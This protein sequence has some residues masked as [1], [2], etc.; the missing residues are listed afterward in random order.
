MVCWAKCRLASMLF[1]ALIFPCFSF[2]SQELFE[3]HPSWTMGTINC[4]TNAGT[5]TM[6]RALMEGADLNDFFSQ[7]I[8]STS[9]DSLPR[10]GVCGCVVNGR[11]NLDLD[12]VLIILGLLFVQSRVSAWS[13]MYFRFMSGNDGGF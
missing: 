2:Q 10:C 1:L 4:E 13:F 5:H 11:L 3:K 12:C 8:P 7:N 9:N 6:H